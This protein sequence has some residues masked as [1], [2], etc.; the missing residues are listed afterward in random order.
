MSILFV[1]K[2]AKLFLA[3]CLAVLWATSSVAAPKPAPPVVIPVISACS[4]NT[5]DVTNNVTANDGCQVISGIGN[6]SESA[7]SGM[8]S[9]T[10]WK[11]L[12]KVDPPPGST[13]GGELTLTGGLISGTW[14]VTQNLLSSYG[15]IMLL[16]KAGQDHNTDP[17]ATVGYLIST[18]TGTYNSPLYKDDGTGD[19]RDISHVTL[20][21][22]DPSPIPL[23]AGGVLLLTALAGLGFARRR[24]KT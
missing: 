23:P 18:L 14:T 8:F 21:V 7:V 10:D 11:Q 1:S 13:S 15:K 9:I 4:S 6:D 12:G 22:S 19:Q 17:A 24:K 2:S 5:P 20:Y 16:F 3:G